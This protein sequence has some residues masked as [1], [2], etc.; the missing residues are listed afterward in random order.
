MY[1]NLFHPDQQFEFTTCQSLVLKRLLY[2]KAPLREGGTF[3]HASMARWVFCTW[4][5]EL[6]LWDN[7]FSRR[8]GAAYPNTQATLKVV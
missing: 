2:Y 6:G 5:D 8:V 4:N 3:R 1:F 7:C